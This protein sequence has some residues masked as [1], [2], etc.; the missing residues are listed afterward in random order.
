MHW[1]VSII[2]PNSL[3]FSRNVLQGGSFSREDLEI[4]CLNVLNK[5]AD[6]LRFF[7]KLYN[8][9]DLEG[10]CLNIL[11]K[12][13]DFLKFF[14]KLQVQPSYSASVNGRNKLYAYNPEPVGGKNLIE[15]LPLSTC[16]LSDNN[17]RSISKRRH[18]LPAN[19]ASLFPNPN[20][21][22]TG[23]DDNSGIRKHGDDGKKQGESEGDSN[24]RGSGGSYKPHGCGKPRR[25][26]DEGD[27]DLNKN[28]DEREH[29]PRGKEQPFVTAKPD[30]NKHDKSG[31]ASKSGGA[32]ELQKES[33]QLQVNIPPP[34]KK[35]PPDRIPA[36]SCLPRAFVATTE[37]PVQ[38]GVLLQ[39]ADLQCP[40]PDT[41]PYWY[42]SEVV[43]GRDSHTVSCCIFYS[44]HRTASVDDFHTHFSVF[45][46]MNCSWRLSGLS[47][48]D[49]LP[50]K[51][52]FA[53][54]DYDNHF[55][56][57]VTV[58]IVSFR[59]P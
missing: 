5:L 52:N 29:K 38:L 2:D 48:W 41:K 15:P 7:N 1:Q 32:R 39:S 11:N 16:V 45:D 17:E 51:Y 10:L 9:L 54:Q 42:Q 27:D 55:F 3:S 37:A 22:A 59:L 35:V 33:L 31:G 24:G 13:V 30:S 14:N 49:A 21:S 18:S 43:V 26:G 44:L 4:M 53:F 28:D 36:L 8:K 19:T 50:R 58:S 47:L 57:V 25:G 12:L 23:A 20:A 56:Q 34:K 46:W 40:L 6:F